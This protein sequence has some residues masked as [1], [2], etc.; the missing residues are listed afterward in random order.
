MIKVLLRL[1][2][3]E[4]RYGDTVVVSEARAR[5][6]IDAGYARFLEHV[7]GTDNTVYTAP[8]ETA[9]TATATVVAADSPAV[10]LPAKSANKDEWV[11]VAHTLGID[12]EDKT[13]DQLIEAVSAILG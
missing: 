1:P 10:D 8:N 12:T 11:A 5:V 9:T 6:L 4:G 2:V 7:G 13:K 3:P